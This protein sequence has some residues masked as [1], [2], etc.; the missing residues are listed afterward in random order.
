MRFVNV[1]T[2]T[3]PSF[4]LLRSSHQILTSM[5]ISLPCSRGILLPQ[6]PPV[7]SSFCRCTSA[8]RQDT[9]DRVPAAGALHHPHGQSIAGRAIGAQCFGI[10]PDTSGTRMQVRL[11][12]TSSAVDK[13]AGLY[14]ITV[15]ASNETMNGTITECEE[16][17]F[18]IN[19]SNPRAGKKFSC[20]WCC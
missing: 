14:Y 4:A 18:S 3:P 8:V 1:S 20:A 6:R 10:T 15:A 12:V 7:Q 13:C 19:K 17:S 5:P 16:V 2:P 9:G 11:C